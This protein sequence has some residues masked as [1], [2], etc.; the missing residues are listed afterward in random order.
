[1]IV[2]NEIYRLKEAQGHPNVVKLIETYEID[3]HTDNHQTF[4]VMELADKSLDK[5]LQ[6]QKGADDEET[7]NYFC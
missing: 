3:E 7:M 6:E 4:I 2:K 1:M 5:H